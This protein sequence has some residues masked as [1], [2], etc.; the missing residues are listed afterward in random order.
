MVELGPKWLG[1]AVTRREPLSGGQE[2]SENPEELEI[3]AQV[4]RQNQAFTLEIRA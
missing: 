4:L 1:L 2:T 3:L